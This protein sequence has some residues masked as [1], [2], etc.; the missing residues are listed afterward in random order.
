MIFE[1]EKILSHFPPVEFAFAYGSGAIK[2]GSYDY[3]RPNGSE[4]PMLDLILVVESSEEWHSLNMTMN[5]KHYTSILPLTASYVAKVQDY[6]PAH[7]WFN[8]YIPIPERNDSALMK[9]GV[10][11]KSLFLDDLNRW[12]NIYAAGRLHKP[13]NVIKDN[14][15]V[16]DAMA[17][18]KHHAVCTSLLLL[19]Q[20]FSELELYMCIA[21]L[22]YIGDPRML[23]GENPKKYREIYSHQIADVSKDG[24]LVATRDEQSETAVTYTFKQS[25]LASDRWKL[26]QQLPDTLNRLLRI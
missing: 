4:G 16:V 20:R 11:C 6:I 3:N 9:Y 25:S 15:E 10:I 23:F 24:Q 19:P 2:Q 1:S 5:P 21:S 13:V 8:A 12:T 18:N 17:V 14:P 26:C 22:S 7:F